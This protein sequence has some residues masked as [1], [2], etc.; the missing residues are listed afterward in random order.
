MIVDGQ[1]FSKSEV[2]KLVKSFNDEC[3]NVAGDF[4]DRCRKGLL[5]DAGRSE[6][7]RAFW[8]EIGFRCGQDPQI[9]YV[10]THYLNFAE[11]V[12]RAWAGL[13]ARSDVS[14]KDKETIHKA[15]IVQ[16]MLG[17]ESQAT[18][19]QLNKDSQQFAGDPFEVR[20]TAKNYGTHAEPSLINRLMNSTKVH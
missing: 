13:L 6:K 3:R 16:E 19:I 2:R 11:D 10:E 14:D 7:F 4:F 20:E 5:G 15:L 1:K 12:R 18:P 8:T 9:C 17:L